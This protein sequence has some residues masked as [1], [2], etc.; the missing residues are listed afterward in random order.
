MDFD[1]Y[2]RLAKAAYLSELLLDE[3]NA[4]G[5]AAEI[6]Y[7]TSAE[8]FSYM[9]PEK[10]TKEEGKEGRLGKLTV[11]HLSYMND[12]NEGKTLQKAIYGPSY[13]AL[14]KGRKPLDVPFVFVKCFSPRIDYLPMWEM[15][16]DHARG[17][18]LVIDWETSKWMEEEAGLDGGFGTMETPLSPEWIKRRYSAFQKERRTKFRSE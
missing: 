13:G 17:C 6:A 8:V 3:L 1:S 15:Y 16:G 4:E 7:Y 18:C 10:C 2:L 12:P 11:M 9:L 14:Q 5:D